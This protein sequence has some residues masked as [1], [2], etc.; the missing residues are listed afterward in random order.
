VK[1][2][3]SPLN[4]SGKNPETESKVE[5][6]GNARQIFKNFL[7]PFLFSF[8]SSLFLCKPSK[9]YV[10]PPIREKLPRRR[11]LLGI[12][13]KFLSSTFLFPFTSSPH[14]PSKYGHQGK[15]PKKQN[16]RRNL[17]GKAR[18]MIS[19]PT[20]PSSL[21]SAPPFQIFH[22]LKFAVGHPSGKNSQYTEL[23]HNSPGKGQ[24]ISSPILLTRLFHLLLTSPPHLTSQ[25]FQIFHVLKFDV[26]PPIREKFPRNRTKAEL[27]RK[28]T[29]NVGGNL[30]HCWIEHQH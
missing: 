19:S 1:D 6:V 30:T 28:S 26:G 22:V 8:L 11:N 21:F 14:K 17:S 13:N 4:T 16:K 9:C 10:R 12:H 5:L 24:I 27:I 18:Q 2:S 29:A 3:S 23:R 20:L 7:L 25:T 15:I